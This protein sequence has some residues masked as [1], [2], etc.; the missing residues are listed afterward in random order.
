M[1]YGRATVT[2]FRLD[3]PVLYLRAGLDHPD[4]N[5]E[6]V[7]LA[8]LAALQNAPLTLLNHHTGHHSFETADDDDA[9]RQ[10]IDQTIAFVKNA[11]SPDFTPQFARGILLRLR[12]GN[13][14][15]DSVFTPLWSR[16]DF[17]A[18]FQ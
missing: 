4:M 11:T 15:T 13:I 14:R 3:L 10:V 2:S 17:Q 18:R 9:T 7:K 5:A 8:S 16:E 1:Y 6:I 12:P